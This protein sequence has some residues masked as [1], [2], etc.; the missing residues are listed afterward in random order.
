MSRGVIN[1]M[2]MCLSHQ[3]GRIMWIDQ[4]AVDQD[5]VLSSTTSANI[6]KTAIEAAFADD[7]DDDEMHGSDL[8][9]DIEGHGGD[10]SE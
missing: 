8:R 10:L 7:R 5:P 3:L 4:W 1:S 6:G 2:K 9:G